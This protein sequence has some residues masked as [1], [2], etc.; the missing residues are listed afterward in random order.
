MA[1]GTLLLVTGLAAIA[2]KPTTKVL[3]YKDRLAAQF[4]TVKVVKNVFKVNPLLFFRGEV[5]L[6]YERAL[7]PR[8][9]LELGIGVTLRNYLALSF[10]GDDADDFGAGTEI[11]PNPSFHIGARYYLVDDLEPQGWYVQPV[12][13]HLVYTKDIREKGPDGQFIDKTRRD[14]RIYNDLRLLFGYQTL[15]AG[16]NWV[17]DFY[18]GAAYRSRNQNIVSE[19]LDLTTQQ[20]SYSEEE[21]TDAVPAFFLGMK[22]GLGF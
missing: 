6:Y 2:Q 1:L 21:K 22:I 16:S 10:V 8:L 19:R 11:V 13:S 12:F 14:E 5:P 20:F 9:S 3:L 4:D 17:L 7:T 18:G 15:G